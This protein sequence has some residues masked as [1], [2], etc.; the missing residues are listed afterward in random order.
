M[1]LDDRLASGNF[2]LQDQRMAMHWIWDNIREFGGNPERITLLGASTGAVCVGLHM[3]SPLS[4]GIFHRAIGQSGTALNPGIFQ[5]DAVQNALDLAASLHCPTDNL[6]ATMDCLRLTSVHDL[7]YAA[8]DAK[9]LYAWLPVIDNNFVPDDPV[10]LLDQGSFN[11]VDYLTGM[12]SQEGYS[13]LPTFGVNIYDISQDELEDLIAYSVGRFYTQNLDI[14]RRT[15]IAEYTSCQQEKA[16]RQ[17]TL[18]E[19]L[20]DFNYIMPMDLA[21]R[22]MTKRGERKVFLYEFSHRPSLSNLPRELDY[23]HARRGD[24]FDFVMGQLPLSATTSEQKLSQTLQDAWIN[25]AKF[26]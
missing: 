24:E 2:G 26:G 17:R 21:A 13:L 10:S 14:I 22:L 11:P 25:F 4:R 9:H 20:T 19:F 15:I 8:S 3:I 1:S 23:I 18:V 12:N 7:V 6:Q 5:T 16:Q